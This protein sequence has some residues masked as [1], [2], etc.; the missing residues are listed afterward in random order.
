MAPSSTLGAHP[1][2]DR[3]NTPSSHPKRLSIGV[4]NQRLLPDDASGYASPVFE[5]KAGQMELGKFSLFF[6]SLCY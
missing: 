2:I 3:F 6:S 1:G 4:P 5:G